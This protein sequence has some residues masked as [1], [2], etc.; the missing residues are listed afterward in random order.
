VPGAATAPP[1]GGASADYLAWLLAQP[2]VTRAWVFSLNRGAGTVDDA[3]VMDGRA[4][5]IP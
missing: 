4:N 3:F 2:G 5:I 1:Q